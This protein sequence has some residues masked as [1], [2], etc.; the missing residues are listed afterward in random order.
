MSKF[1]DYDNSLRKLAEEVTSALEL[2]K[3]GSDQK[4]QV[5]RLMELEEVFRKN[6]SEYHQSREVYRKFMLLVVVKNKNI[7]SARP[8]FREKSKT[9]SGEITPA[10]KNG[11]IK[12]LQS[13]HINY[14]LIK[15]IKENW[16]GEFPEKAEKLYGKIVEARRRLIENNMP[17]AINRA[18]LFYR[19]VPKNHLTL[20]DLIGISAMGLVS[21][22][23]K[24]VGEYSK[25]F[26]GVCIGRMT[27]NMI[28]SYSETTIHFYPSDRSIL[29]RANSLKHRLD[30]QDMDKL[31][32]AINN[33][34]EEDR[35]NGVKT[36][37][38]KITTDQLVS[39][40]NASSVLSTDVSYEAEEGYQI[41]SPILD[42]GSEQMVD[43]AEDTTIEKD[44]M[45]KMF[46]GIKQ[47]PIIQQ[48]ILRLKG[49]R[50]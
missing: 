35:K 43:S 16:L 13:F 42:M 20:M 9:F 6:I 23:D 10:I 32:E 48:K 5:E 19:K 27:G 22:V 30:I 31:V 1:A 50:L 7:L 24:W 21:G 49:V 3:D 18:K 4:E 15:F 38:E 25:V 29:Y 47:L 11:D 44:L 41:S 37:K 14:N 2:N 39:L 40:M 12:K 28:D 45:T 8:Y 36:P 46:A 26:N 33:S 34:Y 17:L